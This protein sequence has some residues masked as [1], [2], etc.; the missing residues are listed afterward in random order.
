MFQ[1]VYEATVI[2]NSPEKTPVITVTA[3]DGDEGVFGTVSYSLVG[4]H[5]SDFSVN[6]NTG[7]VTV[8][9]PALLDRETTPDITIQVM[10]SDGAPPDTRRTVAVPVS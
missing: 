2:E 8:T 1:P 5:S 4:E 3:T 9:N 10:A 6:Y 7:Q